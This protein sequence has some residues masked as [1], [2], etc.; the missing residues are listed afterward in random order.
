MQKPHPP[1]W[2]PG[3]GSKETIDFVAAAPL[4]YMGIPYFHIDFFQ[5][6]FDLFRACA[7][8]NGYTGPGA[9]RLA[10]ADLRG[11]E[12]RTSASRVRKA[13]LVLSPATC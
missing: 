6:N 7:Q 13:S 1:I 9:A 8:K 2:I 4:A 3:A 5:R 10:V 11:R 12:R